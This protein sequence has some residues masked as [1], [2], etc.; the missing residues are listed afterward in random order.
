MISIIVGM[1]FW[2]S[3]K[4]ES[5][6]GLTFREADMGILGAGIFIMNISYLLPFASIPVFVGDKRFFAAESALGLYPAW[7]YGLSQVSHR[8]STFEMDLHQGN[9]TISYKLPMETS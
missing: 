9:E 5:D 3:G 2:Q 4:P 1:I 8:N 7:M 6:A